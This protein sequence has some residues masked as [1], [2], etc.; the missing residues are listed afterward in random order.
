MLRN[1]HKLL[2]VIFGVYTYLLSVY[3]KALEIMSNPEKV[4]IPPMRSMLSYDCL[5][6]KEREVLEEM[7]KFRS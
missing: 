3:C 4:R 5:P 1:E 2:L 7:R 6:P